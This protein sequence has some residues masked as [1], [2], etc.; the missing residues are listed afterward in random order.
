M[1]RGK[2]DWGNAFHAVRTRRKGCARERQR[3]GR[4][5]QSFNR[6]RPT[7][8]RLGAC[9]CMEFSDLAQHNG[10][11]ALNLVPEVARTTPETVSAWSTERS[12]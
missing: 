7:T 11:W 5:G 2:A 1:L 8:N 12:L 9:V 10:I 4:V 3:A 6:R